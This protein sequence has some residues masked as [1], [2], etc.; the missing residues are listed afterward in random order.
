D[1]GLFWWLGMVQ[2]LTDLIGPVIAD[3]GCEL[4][5][6]EHVGPSAD[7]ILRIY[8]DAP[9]GVSVEDCEK[10][11]NEV[12]AV[13]DVAQ[14]QGN[15]VADHSFLEVSSPGLDRPLA[16]VAHFQRFIGAKARVKLF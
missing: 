11:S 3:L 12:D 6:L 5:H 9:G 16:T 8:I 2:K 7:R 1:V 14:A 10:V 15:G 13:L 4:C